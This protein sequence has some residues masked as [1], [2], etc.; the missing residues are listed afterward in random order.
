M[1]VW[2]SKSPKLSLKGISGYAKLFNAA[3]P[4][5]VDPIT[6]PNVVAA[7]AAFEATLITPNA[8]FDKYLRGDANALT[9]EQKE[10]LKLFMDKGCAGCHAGINVGGTDVCAV[11]RHREARG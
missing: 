2:R 10:G 8:P 7:I 4:S 6:M 3:F 1:R 9:A 11:R 5:D